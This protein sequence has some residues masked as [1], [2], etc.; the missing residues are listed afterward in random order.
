MCNR[1]VLGCL[2][3]GCYASCMRINV[4]EQP[5]TRQRARRQLASKICAAHQ[6]PHAA[7]DCA[8]TGVC[9]RTQRQSMTW[10]QKKADV[11]KASC[12][13]LRVDFV[14][15]AGLITCN[16]LPTSTTMTFAL[17]CGVRRGYKLTRTAPQAHRGSDAPGAGRFMSA[18]S[19]VPM[20]LNASPFGPQPF[21]ASYMAMHFSALS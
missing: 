14:R 5:S 21:H 2:S 13:G 20:R 17:L 3:T 11:A 6:Y 9:T 7:A 1:T 18:A 15:H 8:G 19:T 4:S 12:Q 10:K 16:Q